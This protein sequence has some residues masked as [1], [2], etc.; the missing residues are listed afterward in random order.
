[1]AGVDAGMNV[2]EVE[3]LGHVLQRSADQLAQFV[4]ALTKA[5]GGAGWQGADAQRFR[6]QWWPQHRSRLVELET[7]LRGFGQSALNNATEQRRASDAGQ[8][9]VGSGAAG[10]PVGALVIGDLVRLQPDE[11]VALWRSLTKEQQNALIRGRESSLGELEFVAPEIRYAANRQLVFDQY[12]ALN[13]LQARL[14]QL[15]DGLKARQDLYER[16]LRDHEQV[17]FFDPGGDGRIAVV[18]GDLSSASH[19]AVA[20][21][22]ISNNLENYWNLLDE[23]KRLKGAAGEGAAV[24]NWLG[25]DTP[26]GVGWNPIRMAAEI[27]NQTLAEPGAHALTTF[28]QGLRTTNPDAQITV[29]GHSYG[30]LVTGLAARNGLAADNVVFIGSPGVGVDSAHDFR[31]PEGAHVYA[32]E[33]SGGVRL[34]DV[35]FGGDFVSNLGHNVHPFGGVPTE[36]DF[37]ATVLDIGDRLNAFGSHSDY[38]AAGSTSLNLL[39]SIVRGEGP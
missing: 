7:E 5:V 14:G 38:Y 3:D 36:P 31:L 2:A 8:A 25:Y 24:V 12:I 4:S 27:P 20:V 16:I 30:S 18:Q 35:G 33:P 21:P 34:G 37:G 13:D 28:V 26:V 39:G 6:Q 10:A 9:V 1:M 15:P 17:L 11:Q 32:A 23:G 19:V 29:I 22:G